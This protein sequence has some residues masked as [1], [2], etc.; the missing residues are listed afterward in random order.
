MLVK[1]SSLVSFPFGRQYIRDLLNINFICPIILTDGNK[2]PKFKGKSYFWSTKSG[3]IISYPNS[4]A[5]IGWSSMCYNNS[6]QR[7]EIGSDFKLEYKPEFYISI[8]E[9]K[10]GFKNL[11]IDV[12]FTNGKYVISGK[13]FSLNELKKFYCKFDKLKMFL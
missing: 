13:E 3:R 6:T 11:E 12:N 7:I 9:I 1:A 4:Y 2:P 5:K 8:K 10:V